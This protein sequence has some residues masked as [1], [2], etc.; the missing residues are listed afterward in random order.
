MASSAMRNAERVLRW[1]PVHGAFR[2]QR[3]R[4]L[5]VLTYHRVLETGPFGRQL[6]WLA[7][8]A[9]VVSLDEVAAA[10]RESRRLPDHSVLITIDDA[11][12][13]AID[14]AVPELAA[15]GLPAVMFV[16]AS[17]VDADAPFWWDEV[18][19]LVAH[20]AT[21]PSVTGLDPQAAIEALKLLP[22]P[23]RSAEIVE[24]RATVSSPAPRIVQI[25]AD[26]VQRIASQGIAIGSHSLTHPILPRCDDAKVLDEVSR[27]RTVLAD[28]LGTPPIAFAYPNGDRDERVRDAVARAGYELA[29]LFDH[30][31]VRFPL[32]DPLRVSRLRVDWNTN[33]DRLALVCGGLEPAVHR[34]RRRGPSLTQAH[35]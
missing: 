13:T 10:V 22:D 31:P 19:W 6:D 35:G 33:T 14:H 27:S 21:S 2:R 34:R 32:D 12:R 9:H 5:S 24:L 28:I 23:R 1:S 8:H 30:R 29:F 26:E 16:V 17:L 20:G 25:R 4:E 15:R 18:E 7:G 11:D 3:R